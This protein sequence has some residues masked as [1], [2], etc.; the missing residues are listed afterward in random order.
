MN[1]IKHVKQALL[2]ALHNI[3]LAEKIG[4]D[5]ADQQAREK[6]E[7]PIDAER[8]L[9]EAARAAEHAAV[10]AAR[11]TRELSRASKPW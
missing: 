4:R 3:E 9:D 1:R 11:T 2:D 7:L 10:H 8:T 5:I 6:I